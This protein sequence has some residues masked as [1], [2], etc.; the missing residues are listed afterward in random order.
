MP[1]SAE[2][3]AALLELGA[4]PNCT[5]A[6]G[7]APPILLAAAVGNADVKR[8]ARKGADCGAVVAGGATVAP[9]PTGATSRLSGLSVKMARTAEKPANTPM[10]MGGRPRAA[11]PLPE[12]GVAPS[13][14][15][16]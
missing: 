7:I 14:R 8:L 5:D 12:G 1:A 13:T 16:R 6:R 4:D 3:C 9:A 10:P 15:V 2:A 11:P